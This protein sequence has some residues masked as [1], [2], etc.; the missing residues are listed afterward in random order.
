MRKFK[1]TTHLLFQIM[2]K[3]NNKKN[4]LKIIFV[5]LNS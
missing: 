1:K 5:M 4:E 3:N 2:K